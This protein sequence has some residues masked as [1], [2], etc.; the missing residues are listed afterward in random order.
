MDVLNLSVRFIAEQN[1]IPVSDVSTQTGDFLP[2]NL[3][4]LAIA[5]MGVIIFSVI[6]YRRMTIKSS[7]CSGPN[8][9][10]TEINTAL[11]FVLLICGILFLTGF[12][13]TCF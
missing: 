9:E 1:D 7:V 8:L 10:R 4:I 2:I 12:F 3:F 6:V 11:K 5:F 13:V